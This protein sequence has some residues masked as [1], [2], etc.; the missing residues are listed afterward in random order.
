MSKP[1]KPLIVY[2]NGHIA[3]MLFHFLS[4]QHDIVAFTVDSHCIEKP[5]IESTPL[6]PFENI[7]AQ[8]PSS[9]Y[10]MIIAVG[11]TKMN[12]IREQKYFEAKQKGYT[13]IN[14]I[15]P[16]VVLHNNFKMGDN[17]I[18]LEYVSIHPYS[19]LGSGCFISSN[20]NVGHGCILEDF[21]WLNAGVSIGGESVLG[22]QSFLG[23]NSSISQG[24]R[25]AKESFIGANS[26][27][28]KDTSPKGVYF[29]EAA[30]K[31]RLESDSFLRFSSS[32]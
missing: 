1:N 8:Y 29:T 24:I 5:T 10:N 6:V 7:E 18:I 15:H 11:F 30:T 13:L 20:T 4:E 2:G 25:V 23:M 17:N 3:K 12:A 22:K 28:T 31:F 9:N 16:S 32:I 21:C 27:I 14:Y 19:Q 26:L